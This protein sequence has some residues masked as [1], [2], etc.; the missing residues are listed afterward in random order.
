MGRTRRE[1]T[2]NDLFGGADNLDTTQLAVL[3]SLTA[4]RPEEVIDIE[5]GYRVSQGR[6]NASG[7]LYAMEFRN[8]II[9]VGTLADYSGLP[10]RQN[11]A[12]SYR[13]GIELDAN[14]SIDQALT[15]SGNISVHQ[16]RLRSFIG[17]GTLY[18]NVASPMSPAITSALTATYQ[19]L[20][21]LRVYASGQGRS[22]ANLDNTGSSE[23]ALPSAVTVDVGGTLIFGRTSLTADALNISGNRY[24]SG[25]MLGPT[26]TYFAAAPRALFFTLRYAF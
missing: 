9:S 4:V 25:A 6:L 10:L 12:R 13:R 8:E 20:D 22:K 14:Y 26:T 19:P 17:E 24:T 3:G 11:V 21:C 15:L 7:T 2:R 1:P 5:V 23:R 18:A 16:A